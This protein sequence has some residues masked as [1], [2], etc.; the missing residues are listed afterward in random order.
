LRAAGGERRQHLAADEGFKVEDGQTITFP[1]LSD[2]NCVRDK[3]RVFMWTG[4]AIYV[5][6]NLFYSKHYAEG[7]LTATS[8]RDSPSLADGSCILQPAS[9]RG[10]FRDCTSKRASAVTSSSGDGHTTADEK[11]D[12]APVSALKT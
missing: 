9:R 4:Y 1:V 8:V 5:G 7:E 11:E 12:I 6:P 10:R 2:G 3:A